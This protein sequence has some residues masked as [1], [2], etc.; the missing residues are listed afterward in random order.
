MFV[1]GLLSLLQVWFLPGLAVLVFAKKLKIIDRF[2]LSLPLSI[3][4]NYII[5]FS[6]VLLN[7]YNQITISILIF[8]EILLIIIFL[9]KIKWN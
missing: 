5:I 8:I 9:K 2:L 7:S 3:T 4:V 1:L 6:L